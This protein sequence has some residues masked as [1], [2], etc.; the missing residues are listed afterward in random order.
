[1]THY[2]ADLALVAIAYAA[3]GWAWKRLM[4]AAQPLEDDE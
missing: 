3:L 2:P 1:M 4:D